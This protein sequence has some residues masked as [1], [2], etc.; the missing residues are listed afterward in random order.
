MEA[1][2]ETTASKATRLAVNRGITLTTPV[3]GR[4]T[5]G[6]TVV[7]NDKALPVKDDHFTLTTLFQDKRTR[8]WEEHPLK[9]P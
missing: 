6:H 8:V 9:R 7:K 2:A 4:I 5:A 1:I 3:I